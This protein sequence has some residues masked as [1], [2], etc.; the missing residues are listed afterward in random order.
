[1]RAALFLGKRLYFISKNSKFIFVTFL[2]RKGGVGAGFIGYG[3]VVSLVR[4]NVLMCYPVL[5]VLRT[6]HE[7]PDDCDIYVIYSCLCETV[8]RCTYKVSLLYCKCNRQF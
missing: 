1:M 7:H 5:N 2:A 3:I 4:G 8:R 6:K